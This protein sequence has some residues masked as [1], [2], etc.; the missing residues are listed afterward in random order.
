MKTVF[1]QVAVQR[2]SRSDIASGNLLDRTIPTAAAAARK[3]KNWL[4]KRAR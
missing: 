1:A 2:S 3:A 4:R